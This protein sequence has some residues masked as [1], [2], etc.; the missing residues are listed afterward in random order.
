MLPIPLRWEENC[1]GAFPVPNPAEEAFQA[2]PFPTAIHPLSPVPPVAG[3]GSGS[4]LEQQPT[5]SPGPGLASLH[6]HRRSVSNHPGHPDPEV[7][8]QMFTADLD[9]PAHPYPYA[10]DVQVALLRTRYYYTKYLLHRPYI[11]K[12]LHHPDA[13]TTDDARGVA[14]C[15]RAALKWPVTM[16]PTCK[17]K[18]LIPCLY[19]W[20]QNVLGVLLVLH[21]ARTDGML[22]QIVQRGLCGENWEVAAGETVELYV[23]W[24]RDLKEADPAAA[25]AWKIVRAVY[26]FQEEG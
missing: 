4:T 6:N 22:R 2:T 7:E 23:D 21:M 5:L 11:Y 10:Y 17:R 1:P 18:R 13:I 15:L 14:T 26:G 24:L 3:T 9:A 8:K 12:A 20:T 25:F 16:S 19:F